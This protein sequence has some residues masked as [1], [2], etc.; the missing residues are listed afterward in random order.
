[1]FSKLLLIITSLWVALPEYSVGENGAEFPD[2]GAVLQ[3][4]PH[5]ETKPSH[6]FVPLDRCSQK[7]E[8]LI[9]TSLWEGLPE[10][11]VGEHCAEFPDEGAVL[12]QLPAQVQRD[13]LRVHHTLP[14]VMVNRQEKNNFYNSLL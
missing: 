6:S 8:L 2:E 14:V 7:S 1:M 12:Q 5:Q 9:I 11:S 10:Y 4:F 13:I 3:Q